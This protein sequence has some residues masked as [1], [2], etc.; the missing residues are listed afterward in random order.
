MRTNGKKEGKKVGIEIAIK[1]C[2][3][4]EIDEDF[5]KPTKGSKSSKE[6][7]ANFKPIMCYDTAFLGGDIWPSIFGDPNNRHDDFQQL[8]FEVGNC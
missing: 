1:K 4:N 5:Y 2:L 8:I 6:F 7:L 3:R